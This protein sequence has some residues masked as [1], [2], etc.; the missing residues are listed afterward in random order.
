MKRL[1]LPAF[2]ILCYGISAAQDD[3]IVLKKNLRTV[4]TYF[5]GTQIAFTTSTRY[6]S[7][8]IS[9]IQKDSIDM[10]EYDIRQLPTR[11]GVYMLDTVATYRS[12][13]GY[14]DIIKI[15]NERK[16]FN[17]AASG[18]SLLGGGIL[19]TAIGL[20][21][22]LFTKPGDRYHASPKL[23][24]GAAALGATGYI[25]MKTSDKNFSIGKKYHLNYI[26]TK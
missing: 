15:Q 24:V 16:G 10:L 11:L 22:W 3:F 20:G 2:F 23:I 13:I 19:I 9:S 7:G 4:K 12:R 5:T 17:F 26:R 25:L 21:T 1:L 18:A 14:R 8:R 6:Y